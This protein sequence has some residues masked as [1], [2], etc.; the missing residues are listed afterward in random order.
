VSTQRTR[1]DEEAAVVVTD[2][3]FAIEME[4]TRIVGP[5]AR[6]NNRG[7]FALSRLA[8]AARNKVRAL[9]RKREKLKAA[10]AASS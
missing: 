7:E 9:R 6:R 1:D 2:E 8:P 4:I 3:W 5:N 10:L